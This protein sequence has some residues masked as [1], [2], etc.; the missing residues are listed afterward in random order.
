MFTPY[1][2][3]MASTVAILFTSKV[4]AE[5]AT[6]LNRLQGLVLGT[7]AGQMVYANFGWC[8]PISLA[9]T[10]IIFFF[11]QLLSLFYYYHSTEFGGIFI[12]LAAFGSK[13]I[14]QEC[15]NVWGENTDSYFAIVAAVVAICVIL[16]V[17]LV[18]AP[19]RASTLANNAR[20]EVLGQMKMAVKDLFDPNVKNTTFHHVPIEAGINQA[21]SLCLE[22]DAEPRVW[23]TPF[24]TDLFLQFCDMLTKLRYVLA[25]L[26]V[27]I[28]DSFVEGEPKSEAFQVMMKHSCVST[29]KECLIGKI[30]QLER[31]SKLLEHEV[32]GPMEGETAPC[33]RDEPEM[34]SLHF[35]ATLEQA[36]V[37]AEKID[38]SSLEDLQLSVFRDPILKVSLTVSC[39]RAMLES[40]TDMQHAFLN[41]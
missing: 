9:A 2:A 38:F 26:E 5:M 29:M 32:D 39:C 13:M 14:L 31:L 20:K 34:L 10:L 37:D 7:V 11:W 1:N 17:D 16:L 23:R 33:L 22:A 18:C 19:D 12:L 21:R 41:Y 35:T 4:G 6:N 3:D 40:M 15:S 25:V 27:S 24:R 28:A 36:V 8:T 30:E